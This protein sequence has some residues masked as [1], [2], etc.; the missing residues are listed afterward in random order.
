MQYTDTLQTRAYQNAEQ[1]EVPL[2]GGAHI[3][4]MY[5]YE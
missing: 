2:E 4:L 1:L 5:F 3:L